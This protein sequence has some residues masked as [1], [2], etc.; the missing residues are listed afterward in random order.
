MADNDTQRPLFK[1]EVY[2]AE[3]ASREV[4][5]VRPDFSIS[6]FKEALA[7]GG[8][9]AKAQ[10]FTVQIVGGPFGL[11]TIPTPGLESLIPFPIPRPAPTST[12]QQVLMCRAAQMPDFY[13]QTT[14]IAFHSRRVK[15]P[16]SR[17]YDPITLTFLHINDARLRQRF[18]DWMYELNHPQLN[19]ASVPRYANIVLTQYDM[20]GRS[21]LDFIIDVVQGQFSLGDRVMNRYV[22]HDAFPITVGGVRL[23]HEADTEVQTYDVQFQYQWIN[24]GRG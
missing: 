13:L 7:S 10:Y 24:H 21:W 22:L 1:T 20:G 4:A 18:E 3:R 9:L 6:R 15:I 14:E 23:D 5:S 19:Q 12:E 17:T 16:S 8:G 2:S 11:G